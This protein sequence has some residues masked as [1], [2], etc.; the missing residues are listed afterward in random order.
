[1]PEET[2]KQDRTPSVSLALVSI[3]ALS[4]HSVLSFG[5]LGPK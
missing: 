3:A 4:L 1:L 5:L 2:C